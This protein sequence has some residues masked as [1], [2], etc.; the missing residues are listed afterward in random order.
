[1][2]NILVKRKT[3]VKENKE[4]FVIL[5]V[6]TSVTLPSQRQYILFEHS[7]LSHSVL[8]EIVSHQTLRN[9]YNVHEHMLY[10]IVYVTR[11]SWLSRYC[12]KSDYNS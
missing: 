10:L 3:G 7:G 4:N 5:S 12:L 2:F 9:C 1:M 11:R 6:V 8:Y